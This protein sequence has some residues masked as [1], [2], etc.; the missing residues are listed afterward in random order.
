MTLCSPVDVTS[1]LKVE[2]A[3]SQVGIQA[4]DDATEQ[5]DLAVLWI[6]LVWM[7]DGSPVC[8]QV[9]RG[10]PQF[11]KVSAGLGHDRFVPNQVKFYIDVYLLFP[12]YDKQ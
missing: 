10:F 4:Q 1:V 8:W 11:L 7:S 6:C 12:N 9:F 2:A 5:V 3:G